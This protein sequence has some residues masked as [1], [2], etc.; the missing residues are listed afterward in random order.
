[1][2]ATGEDFTAD[3]FTDYVTEKYGDLYGIDA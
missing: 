3:A 2:Q 1:V